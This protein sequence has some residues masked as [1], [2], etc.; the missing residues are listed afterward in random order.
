MRAQQELG[1]EIADRAHFF[2]VVRLGRLYPAI[3]KAVAHTVCEREVLVVRGS[4]GREASQD[5]KRVFSKRSLSGFGVGYATGVVGRRVI[6][7]MF[8]PH[9]IP[10]SM[11]ECQARSRRVLPRSWY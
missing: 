1:G 11:R 7:E 2:P 6:L 8:D 9:R 3:E 5:V 10:P 4:G